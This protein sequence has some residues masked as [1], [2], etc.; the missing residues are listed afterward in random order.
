MPGVCSSTLSST[1]TILET[2]KEEE[3]HPRKVTI[4][5]TN[6]KPRPGIVRSEPLDVVIHFG[7]KL[8]KILGRKLSTRLNNHIT[9]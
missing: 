1:D 7:K 6:R 8:Y 4:T 2:I 9:T 3:I 5:T